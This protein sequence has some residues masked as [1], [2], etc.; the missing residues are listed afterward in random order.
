MH[1]VKSGSHEAHKHARQN[2]E[3]ESYKNA[4]LAIDLIQRAI[5]NHQNVGISGGDVGKLCVF[6]EIGEYLDLLEDEASFFTMPADELRVEVLETKDVTRL[7]ETL[8]FGRDLDE[9]L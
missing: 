4:N 1:P 9:L 6:P 5:A 3:V 2:G 7:I 8:K